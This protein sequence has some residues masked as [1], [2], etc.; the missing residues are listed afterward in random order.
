MLFLKEFP[1]EQ[2][3][4]R[5]K[6]VFPQINTESVPAF[7]R[8]LVLGSEGLVYSDKMLAEYGL[9]HARWSVLMLL[10]RRRVWQAL[11]SELAREQGVSRAT[12][13][14]LINRLEKQGLVA[15]KQDTQDRRKS[16]V[17]LTARGANLVEQV[18]PHCLDMMDQAL[19]PLTREEVLQLRGLLE[20]LMPLRLE[21]E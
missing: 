8:L 17:E 9:G 13:T 19:S 1:D 20:K 4:E 15:K 12:M 2:M 18:L 10:R 11:P 21:R 16:V 7:L 5:M 3:L 6:V 14:G